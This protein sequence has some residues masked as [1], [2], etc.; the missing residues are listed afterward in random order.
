MRRL[1]LILLYALTAAFPVRAERTTFPEHT[2][3]FARPD[4][5]SP[6][7]GHFSGEAEVSPE[8][9]RRYTA[10]HPLA[11]GC[12]YRRVTLP[13][14]RTGYASPRIVGT[15]AETLRQLP[16][17][18]TAYYFGAI[19]A[20]G[21]LCFAAWKH[22]SE[23]RQ[24]LFAPGSRREGAYFVLEALA[25]RCSLAFLTLA[26]FPDVIPAAADD[27]GYFE[28]GW[29]ILHGGF[30]KPW[31]FTIGNGL[32]YLPFIAAFRA[33]EFY[34]IATAVDHF[35][36]FVTS[37]AVLVLGFL[38]L[39]RLGVSLYGAAAALFAAALWPFTACHL[40]NWEMCRFPAFFASPWPDAAAPLGAWRFYRFCIGAGFNAMS[41]T[42][43]LL[44]LLAAIYCALV[45]RPGR[46]GAA[47]LGAVYGAACLFR[48][49]YCFF[50]PLI[51]FLW[52]RRLAEASAPARQYPWTALFAAAGFFAVFS[53][54]LAVNW[55]DFGAPWR[56]GYVLHYLDFPEGR[57]PADGFTIRTLLE[58]RNLR[59][60][61]GANNAA[62]ALFLAGTWSLRDRVLR[63]AFTLWAAPVTI[64]FLG[65]Y[66]TYCDAA[67]F[68]LPVFA[69]F[70]GAF[71]AAA[72]PAAEAKPAYAAA[73]IALLVTAVCG[74]IA[75][76]S[77][78]PDLV[79]LAVAAL[80]TVAAVIWCLCRGDRRPA[81]FAAAGALIFAA[82]QPFL[83][84]AL[85]GA[86]LCRTAADIF[87]IFRTGRVEKAHSP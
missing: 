60:L 39:R 4:F 10:N 27:N 8:P 19:V 52:W 14:G 1:V 75:P 45:L 76:A 11:M 77:G 70:F 15:S 85:L 35:N 41:D 59:F 86:L 56:F 25:L 57:R 26:E 29:G 81:F 9:E 38:V 87:A 31:R 42:P 84:L 7:L 34:D 73:G 64:F 28:V 78:I 65:Y 63:S 66:Q 2:A 82:N 49:N 18:P 13:D 53:W 83:G 61:F 69:A 37:P 6:F 72:F 67:R 44:V 71:G 74:R 55:H 54:Q 21:V 32:W 22:F 80:P 40:E 68:I 33:R 17:F 48:I 20:A 24:G 50:A 12:D 79:T 36:L 47:I 62:W 46:R 51:A 30:P 23:R 3:L 43:G 5:K 58:W 16:E